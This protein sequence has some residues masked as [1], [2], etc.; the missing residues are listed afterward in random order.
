MKKIIERICGFAE[1]DAFLIACFLVAYGFIAVDLAAVG[2]CILLAV[3]TF[4]FIASDDFVLA[5]PP[6][7][8]LACG[9]FLCTEEVFLFFALIPAVL[10]LP[11]LFGITGLLL[12]QPVADLITFL[13][14]IPLQ[15][16]LLREMSREA[17]QPGFGK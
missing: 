2:V 1:T 7:L 3:V 15:I 12:A 9:F 11:R 16:S 6:V 8:M 13:I 14:A 17:A 4:L 5:I 10:A